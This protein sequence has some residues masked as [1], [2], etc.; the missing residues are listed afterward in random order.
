MGNQRGRC[1]LIHDAQLQRDWLPTPRQD[2]TTGD[3]SFRSFRDRAV[4]SISQQQHSTAR[5]PQKLFVTMSLPRSL[6][7]LV[8]SPRFW[9]DYLF[10]TDTPYPSPYEDAFRLAAAEPN[11][12]TAELE[13]PQN[14]DTPQTPYDSESNDEYP[15]PPSSDHPPS[16][17]PSLTLLFPFDRVLD[18]TDPTFN[19][20][21]A[22]DPLFSYIPLAFHSPE[23]HDV[24]IGHDDQAHWHPFVLRW[25]ELELFSK[26]VGRTFLEGE[27]EKGDD[28]EMEA[29]ID[30]LYQHPGLPLL[31]LYRFAPICAGDD[32]EKIV[33]ML[34]KA[35]RRVVGE[36]LKDKD[37]QRLVEKMDFRARGFRWFREGCS[38]WI[39]K[40]EDKETAEGV[41]TYRSRTA[42]ESGE[43]LNAAWSSLLEEA[44]DVVQG[45]VVDGV[46]AEGNVDADAEKKADDEYRELGRMFAPR[47]RHGLNL[48]LLLGEKDRPLPE[49]AGR[50][51]SLTLDGVLRILDIGKAIV[52]GGTSRII[53]GRSVPVSDSIS[54]TVYGNLAHG[55]AVVK[56]MLWWLRASLAT[57]I[58][59]SS[60][61]KNLP[62]DLADETE[63]KTD[64]IY[65]GITVP[66]ILPNCSW[67]VGHTLPDSLGTTLKSKE[68][69]GETGEVT[70]PTADG[71]LTATTADGGEIGFNF[72]RFDDERI[73]GTGAIAL[74]RVTTQ[75]SALLHQLMETSGAVLTPVRLAAKP[76][77]EEVIE[78]EWPPHRIVD[79]ET[80][81]AILS[82]GAFDLWNKAERKSDMDDD[83]DSD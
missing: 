59:D 60:T 55:K 8:K 53:D 44:R 4:K 77:S 48:R 29:E 83:M 14:Q 40:G 18:P 23:A 36:E 70:G 10:L 50:Y 63:E 64:E 54:I 3:L 28:S 71:W 82:A 80:F 30:E 45:V 1:C 26:A 62:F 25:E 27:G 2:L 72:I 52:S 74:R 20:S 43:W 41:Y 11:S 6:L 56:Q 61:Y 46:V 47:E 12:P 51:F 78:I 31:F 42:V 21:S 19:L 49:R 57:T 22:V 32:A 73:Q 37:L 79:A 76:L 81:H 34:V 16:Q 67:L 17:P 15:T 65:L 33:G 75:A 24:T 7:P 35:Y 69:L 5:N 58:W 9:T 39:G 66:D 68:V 38:W 13:P